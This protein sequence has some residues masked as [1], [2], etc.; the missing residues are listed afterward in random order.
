[1]FSLLH[2]ER[3]TRKNIFVPTENSSE[4]KA[5][6]M[7]VRRRKYCVSCG[8]KSSRDATKKKKRRANDSTRLFFSSFGSVAVFSSFR[9]Q[10]DIDKSDL[11]RLNVSHEA[12]SVFDLSAIERLFWDKIS[13]F[14]SFLLFVAVL[15]HSLIAWENLRVTSE[16]TKSKSKSGQWSK[17]KVKGKTCDFYRLINVRQ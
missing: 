9:L 14:F 2:A 8:A 12:K 11:K 16:S 7:S 13:Y 6:P 17:E 3:R 10:Q 1:M 15:P 5:R 4:T